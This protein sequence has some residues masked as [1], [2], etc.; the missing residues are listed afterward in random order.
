MMNLPQVV[1]ILHLLGDESRLRLCALLQ[2]RELTVTELVR[3]MGVSQSS[4]S[5]HLGRLREAGLVR[6]RRRGQHAYYALAADTL[7]A[8]ARALLDEAT[9]ADDPTLAADR[10]RLRA[11]DDAARGAFPEMFAGEMER[12]YSPG[13]TWHSLAMGLA[14]LLDLG[15]VLDV[16]SGDGAAAVHLAPRCRALTC[17]DTSPQM[18][19]AATARLAGFAHVRAEVADAAAMP[20]ADNRFDAVLVFHTLTYAENPAAVLA[21]CARV[22]VPGGRL[23]VLSLDA[24]DAR[25][26]TASFGERHPGFAPARL[27]AMMTDAGLTSVAAQV[28]SREARKPHFSVVLGTGHKPASVAL[29]PSGPGPRP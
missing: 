8:T 25:E 24:H 29:S 27:A 10:Q 9:R 20:F 12:H 26:V 4:V 28:V 16:G 6:D 3:V 17:I 22:L 23:V 15:D 14:A 7:P 2:G 19:A 13:R 11:L 21:E 1:G 5:M 18:V